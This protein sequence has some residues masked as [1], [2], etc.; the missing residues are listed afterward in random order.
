MYVTISTFAKQIVIIGNPTNIYLVTAAGGNFISYL[1]TMIFPTLISGT[2][3]FFCLHLAFH[4][5]LSQPIE[6][7][8]EDV[9]IDDR[10]SLLVGIIH[11]AVC[12]VLLA[13]GSYIGLEMWLV[14]LFSALS[15]LAFT[16][17]IALV[18]KEA[19]V[20]TAASLKR[21]PW[22]LIPFILSMF[23]MVEALRTNGVTDQLYQ[24]LNTASPIWSYGVTSFLAANLIN[25]IPM[26]VLYSSILSGGATYATVYA[27]V[28]GSNLG[29]CLSPI[30]ALAG[31][32]WSSILKKHDLKFGYLDFLKIGITIAVPALIAALAM[33]DL[34]F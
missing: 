12:T 3:A 20:H 17:V 14:A 33:L 6:A 8:P 27:T 24:L 5:K 4:K 28:V 25:N 15:L 7:Q 23:V 30:G 21:A 19:P 11:L 31:I 2:V 9:K 16:L 18:R 29:A 22:E 1:A 13:V 10:V 32:M 34:M 26:S